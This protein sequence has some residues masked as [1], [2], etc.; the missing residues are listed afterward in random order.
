MKYNHNI[1]CINKHII[2]FSTDEINEK[3]KELKRRRDQVR[4]HLI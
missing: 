2:E 3:E 4:D 1:F